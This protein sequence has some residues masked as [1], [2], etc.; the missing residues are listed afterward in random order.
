[1]LVS[2]RD[3]SSF[4]QLPLEPPVLIGFLAA[5]VDFVLALAINF[6][7]PPCTDAFV[8][9]VEFFA[10]IFLLIANPIVIILGYK[11]N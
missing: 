6:E 3:K 4:N 1:M 11:Y 8:V 7:L 5:P 10:A 2:L 9:L